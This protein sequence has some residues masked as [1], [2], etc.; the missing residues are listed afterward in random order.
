LAEL[1]LTRFDGTALPAEAFCKC[2]KLKSVV[3][4]SKIRTIGDGCFASCDIL[5]LCDLPGVEEVGDSAF[6]SSGL[7]NATFFGQLVSIGVEAFKKTKLSLVV[8]GNKLVFMG[9]GAFSGAAELVEV[10][11]SSCSWLL[12]LRG[13]TFCRCGA[14]TKLA[15]PIT[16]KELEGVGH[17]SYAALSELDAGAMQWPAIPDYAFGN[18]PLRVFIFPR[19]LQRI[20][21]GAFYW[22]KLVE[23]DLRGTALTAVGGEAFACAR[24]L[25]VACFGA[26]VAI[27]FHAFSGCVGLKFF[28][29]GD[30]ARIDRFTWDWREGETVVELALRGAATAEAALQRDRI[31]RWVMRSEGIGV[32]GR[33]TAPLPAL[34]G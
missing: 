2:G 8:G 33:S 16:L 34:V 30:A 13:R 7:A 17:F 18:V 24:E 3:G 11:L 21:L 12:A 6:A 4:S 29:S 15:L 25:R 22:T 19:V 1:D 32:F 31:G 10:D 23:V 26:N 28:E 5:S 14:L 20:G 9:T 27:G